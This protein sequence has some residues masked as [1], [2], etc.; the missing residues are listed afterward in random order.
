M[1]DVMSVNDFLPYLFVP[2]VEWCET[3]GGSLIVFKGCL[4]SYRQSVVT[5]VLLL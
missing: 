1:R 5:H 2:S 4:I 3:F